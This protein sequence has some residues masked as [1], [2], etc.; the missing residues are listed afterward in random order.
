MVAI[1]D[2]TNQPVAVL[3]IMKFI[4]LGMSL[5]DTVVSVQVTV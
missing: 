2:G 5:I 3:A 1:M 4:I